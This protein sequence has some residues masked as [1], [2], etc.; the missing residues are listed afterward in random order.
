MVSL[1]TIFYNVVPLLLRGIYES[2]VRS[3]AFLAPGKNINCLIASS[4]PVICEE[5]FSCALLSCLQS[6]ARTGE[7][8]VC[9]L[10]LRRHKIESLTHLTRVRFHSAYTQYSIQS[11]IFAR[12]MECLKIIAVLYFTLV[13]FTPAA[14]RR[15]SVLGS[16]PMVPL[17]DLEMWK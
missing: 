17:A 7:N 1:E 10:L 16:L 12:F 9:T 4:E 3:G 13:D 14:F 8:A 11:C 2:Q 5:R 6:R 15:L